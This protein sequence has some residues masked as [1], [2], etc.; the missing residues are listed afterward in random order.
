M[1]AVM[2]R[3]SRLALIYLLALVAPARAAIDPV[4]DPLDMGRASG[5]LNQWRRIDFRSPG[6]SRG[7]P[8]Q[9][10]VA[11]RTRGPSMQGLIRIPGAPASNFDTGNGL[12]V[13]DLIN[14]GNDS[15]GYA[16][17]SALEIC[18]TQT[19]HGQ[20]FQVFAMDDDK[21]IQ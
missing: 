18:I 6:Q 5:D 1:V 20:S 17:I 19:T 12:T 14:V 9:I 15:S 21:P 11:I 16:E 4:A 2:R 13:V 10:K 8:A 7:N 3:T